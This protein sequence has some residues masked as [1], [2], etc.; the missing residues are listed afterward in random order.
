[1]NWQWTL[2]VVADVV[3]TIIMFYLGVFA[4]HR[5]DARGAIPF[6]VMMWLGSWWMF[7]NALTLNSVDLSLYLFWRRI[8]LLGVSAAPV[9]WLCL[10]LAAAGHNAHLTR[11]N[12]ALLSIVPLATNL[13][14]WV[15]DAD[16]RYVEWLR[17]L[18]I[19]HVPTPLYMPYDVWFITHAIYSYVLMVLGAVVL[20]REVL[21]RRGG[22]H[23]RQFIVLTVGAVIPLVSDLPMTFGLISVP[24]FETAPFA[25]TI[26]GLAWA[27][28]LFR[29]RL[30]DV[31]PAAQHAV[32]A[33]MPD[34]LIVLDTQD[35]IVHVN[36]PAQGL[37]SAPASQVIGHPLPSYLPQWSGLAARLDDP[38]HDEVVVALGA[39]GTQRHF[40]LR[41]S[42]VVDQR[43]RLAGRVLVLRDV[44]QRV[45]LET[46]LR[47]RTAQVGALTRVVVELSTELELDALLRFIVEHAMQLLGGI[48]GGLALYRPAQDALELR[49]TVGAAAVAPLPGTLIRRGEGL[50]GRVWEKRQPVTVD[51]SSDWPGRLDCLPPGPVP[52]GAMVAAPMRWGSEFL[53]VLAISSATRTFAPA[54]AEMLSLFAAYAGI[55]IHNAQLLRSLRESERRVRDLADALPDAV[56]E[57]DDR[58]ML[59]FM[60]RAGVDAFGYSAADLPRGLRALRLLSPTDRRNIWLKLEGGASQGGL[61]V[62]CTALRKDST[63][64]PALLHCASIV[65]DGSLKGWRGIAVDITSRKQMEE[66]IRH[67]LSVEQ[68]LAS[69]STRF[70]N[71]AHD[72]IESE[73]VHALGL[74]GEHVGADSTYVVLLSPDGRTIQ[75]QFEWCAPGIEPNSPA[76]AGLSLTPFRWMVAELRRRGVVN[77]PDV[78]GLPPEADPERQQCLQLGV[79]A[80]LAVSLVRHDVLIGYLGLG[81][82]SASWT[83][84]EAD[85][86]L[87]RLMGD[88]I[89]SL[90]ARQRLEEQIEASLRE[91]EMLL[92]EI[93]HRVKNNLQVVSSLLYLQSESVADEQARRSLEESQHRVKSLA[94]LHEQMYQ[95][96]SLA[97]VDFGRYIE[98]LVCQLRDAY[99][100]R[101]GAIDLW[102]EVAEVSLGLDIAIPCSLIINELVSNALKYA[103]PQ[104]RPP[105]PGA[106]GRPEVRVTFRPH[107]EHEFLLAVSDN[108]IGLPADVDIEAIN[109]LGLR[110]VQLLTRQ[111]R[112]TLCVGR[113]GGTAFSITFPRDR[114]G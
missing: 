61:S 90:V 67:R 21:V 35:R 70:I 80:I 77:V 53:G 72:Q 36:P 63:T 54:D 30:F 66:N 84:S 14:H 85:V 111:L 81:S 105:E 100:V 29:Y 42:P 114:P 99:H 41:T 28:G 110:I 94:L 83:W 48:G 109:S 86:S 19:D 88:I 4:M 7:T 25:L 60:N 78:A 24:G 89:L 18:H 101:A 79:H 68:M 8:M 16:P 91:K 43:Q 96:S 62:E 107:G 95:S 20:A 71:I 74:I 12:L 10:A 32:L 13:L 92:R 73:M 45:Q 27:Y 5:R 65:T 93:H 97:A 50:M 103:F 37:L 22:V 47:Q 64:F 52:P 76:L 57:A 112:G 87:L 104:N 46:A 44:S 113:N 15:R 55:A 38:N 1:M 58:G 108:G 3:A 59:T 40:E 23:R 98:G 9:A 56:F 31:V 2:V 106:R 6:A 102:P 82:H 33:S 11:R 75:R 49:T 69:V 17:Y 51:A 39:G 26:S 34:G